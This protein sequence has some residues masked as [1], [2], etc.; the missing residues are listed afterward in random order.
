MKFDFVFLGQSVLKY[1]VPLKFLSGL[2]NFTKLKRNIYPMPINNSQE[3]FLMKSL[4]SMQVL[5]TKKCMR[6][7]LFQTMF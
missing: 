7:V 4:Y 6:I 3:K 1:Q 5:R 2:M